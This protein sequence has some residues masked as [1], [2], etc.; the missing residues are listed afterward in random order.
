[1]MLNSVTVDLH[2]KSVRFQM[3]LQTLQA[4]YCSMFTQQIPSRSSVTGCVLIQIKRTDIMYY[5]KMASRCLCFTVQFCLL[6]FQ[7]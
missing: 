7:Q 3:L 4:Y 1:M 2:V 5:Q 6:Q